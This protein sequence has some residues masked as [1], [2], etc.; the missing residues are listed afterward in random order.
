MDKTDV[1]IRDFKL[2]LRLCNVSIR[3]DD[4]INIIAIAELVRDKGEN[5]TIKDFIDK[6]LLSDVQLKRGRPKKA[7]LTDKQ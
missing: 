3:F 2:G 6:G 7:G 5:A 1:F 4:A